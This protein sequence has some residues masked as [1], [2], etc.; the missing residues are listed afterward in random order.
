M[1]KSSLPIFGAVSPQGVGYRVN[2]PLTV[3]TVRTVIREKWCSRLEITDGRGGLAEFS[4]MCWLDGQP[5]VVT[6]QIA[7]E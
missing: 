4:A 5:V 2:A 7:G 3:A 6:G 1:S